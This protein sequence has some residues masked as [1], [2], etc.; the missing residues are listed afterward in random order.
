MYIYLFYYYTQYYEFIEYIYQQINL[1][2]IDYWG[3]LANIRQI[4]ILQMS[5]AIN[6]FVN[7]AAISISRGY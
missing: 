4:I 3:K 6:G 1:Q 2:I 5:I 7:Y